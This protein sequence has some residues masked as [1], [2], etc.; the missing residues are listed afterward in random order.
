MNKLEATANKILH[1]LNEHGSAY[2]V[3]GAVRDK[4]LG[5]K[6]KKD[7]SDITT[8]VEELQLTLNEWSNH[9]KKNATKSV[10]GEETVMSLLKIKP[11]P[12]VGKIINETCSW[13]VDENIN[14]SS[15]EVIHQ[16]AH[17]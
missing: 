6:P 9:N 11:G 15:T 4:I 17:L 7:W 8:K 14:L 16:Q 3:G 1:I 10:I 2:I 13:I 5:I 12:I